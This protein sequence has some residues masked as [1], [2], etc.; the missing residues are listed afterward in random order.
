MTNATQAKPCQVKTQVKSLT[1]Y[2]VT[3]ALCIAERAKH[4]WRGRAELAVHLVAGHGIDVSGI[5]VFAAFPRTIPRNSP[6]SHARHEACHG[7]CHEAC[8]GAT[9]NSFSFTAQLSPGLANTVNLPV[10]SPDFL[11]FGPQS[12]ILPLACRGFGRIGAHRKAGV[13]D[14]WGGRQHPADRLGPMDHTL[15]VNEAD[16]GLNG[17]SDSACAN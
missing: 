5:V 7:A 4:V 15:F 8:H 6:Q 16:Q 11:D 13:T 17:R 12:C 9:R 14:R 10:V 1:H 3:D 2:P